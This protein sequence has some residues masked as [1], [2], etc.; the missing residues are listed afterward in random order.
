MF[1]IGNEIRLA[2]MPLAS[3]VSQRFESLVKT[4]ARRQVEAGA[5]WLLLDLGPQRKNAGE[6]LAWLIR[7]VQ[8]E[9]MVPLALRGDDPAALEAG[10]RVARGQV[11]IDATLPGVEDPNVFIDLARRHD[12]LLALS[13]CPGG[14]PTPTEERLTYVSETLLPKAL[15]AGLPLEKFYVDPLVTALTCDQPMVP[16]TVESL[17]LFKVAAEPAPNTLVHLD[18]VADGVADVAKP[19]IT[20]AYLTMLLA[21]GVDT[22]VANA[23][24]PDLLDVLRIV[25][26]RDPV[27]SYD[28]LMLRLYDVTKAEAELEA[29][30]VN[31]DDPEQVKLY[32]TARVLNNELL[33][34]GG[35][36]QA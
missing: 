9:V 22:L 10:I 26:E 36:L 35:Y 21:A 11:L 6:D 17:R 7:A 34:A 2:R 25:Q 3:A 20:Q 15:A 1:L 30:F 32:K 13:A 31:Q 4:M 24:D 27:T 28:R 5:N 16:V 14:L 12:T 23:L 33:Y 18:D 19:Y 8:D 29:A